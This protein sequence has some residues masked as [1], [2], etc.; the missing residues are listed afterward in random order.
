MAANRP[1]RTIK[2]PSK[3]LDSELPMA[4]MNG[5]PNNVDTTNN[6]ISGAARKLSRSVSLTRDDGKVK[7]SPKRRASSI[8]TSADEDTKSTGKLSRQNSMSPPAKVKPQTKSEAEE[9]VPVNGVETNNDKEHSKGVKINNVISKIK[10]SPG[11]RKNPVGKNK[12][13]DN[14]GKVMRKTVTEAPK[15]SPSKHA[16]GKETENVNNAPNTLPVH[17]MVTEIRSKAKSP[18]VKFHDKVD[19]PLNESGNSK[20]SEEVNPTIPI[21]KRNKPGPKP[22]PKLNTK[23]LKSVVGK[24]KA[25]LTKT[26]KATVERVKR[27]YAQKKNTIPIAESTV[28]NPNSTISNND[29]TSKVTTA[30]EI[31]K[32]SDMKKRKALKVVKL[33]TKPGKGKIGSKSALKLGK[34]TK[35]SRL[36]SLETSQNQ[37]EASEQK[38]AVKRPRM[39]PG[40]KPKR[41]KLSDKDESTAQVKNIISPSD[42]GETMGGSSERSSVEKTVRYKLDGSPRLKPGPKPKKSPEESG[43]IVNKISQQVSSQGTEKTV[44]STKGKPGPKPKKSV[45]ESSDIVESVDKSKGNL[46]SKSKKTPETKEEKTTM[47]PKGKG[48]PKPKGTL[49]NTSEVTRKKPGPKPKKA[50]SEPIET[51]SEP[52]DNPKLGEGHKAD[53]MLSSQPVK[54]KPGPK[55]KKKLSE[56]SEMTVGTMKK[57][58]KVVNKH[59]GSDAEELRNS[60][61]NRVKPGPKPKKSLSDSSPGDIRD[62]ASKKKS[63][64]KTKKSPSNNI[65]AADTSSKAKKVNSVD[66]EKGTKSKKEVAESVHAKSKVEVKS[67]TAQSNVTNSPTSAKT[68]KAKN[69][70]SESSNSPAKAKP[71]PKPKKAL[72]E[73]NKSPS[74]PNTESPKQQSKKLKKGAKRPVNL[75]NTERQNSTSDES[76]T[77]YSLNEPERKRFKF[78]QTDS[79]TSSDSEVVLRKPKPVKTSPSPRKMLL[80]D[81][82]RPKNFESETGNVYFSVLCYRCQCVLTGQSK[83]FVTE[84]Y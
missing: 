52:K 40:P 71:G 27:K 12:V 46:T 75:S 30:D 84:L 25:G 36:K 51:N 24:A 69:L 55:P 58:P 64:V 66:S 42:S 17:D 29:Q 70:K 16:K 47:S 76:D 8:E 65:D 7:N 3:F 54:D 56:N 1:A 48:S 73:S 60:Q 14:P 13:H 72:S 80:K 20:G 15:Q 2:P 63:N 23:K 18:T 32:K 5:V 74:K 4:T 61:T 44:A 38:L 35:S 34:G 43:V 6:V 81:S 45:S 67:K 50:L 11:A 22:K 19:Q 83:W 28:S 82:I 53:S 59:L 62:G 79:A 39:K 49:G 68:S 41:I 21:K 26:P 78:D 31:T 57:S 10:A 37:N 33:S 77:L 9:T